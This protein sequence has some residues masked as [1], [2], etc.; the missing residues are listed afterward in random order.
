MTLR[1]CK[2]NVYRLLLM[3]CV[4]AAGN[5]VHAAA[6]CT[7]AATGPV[8]GVYNPLNASPTLANGTVSVTCTWT[9]GG[10]TTVNV[11]SSYTAGN[12]GS[13]ASRFMLSGVNRLNYNLYYDAAFTQIRGDGTGGSQ[14]G[15]ATLVVSS[16]TR[17]DSAS[18][19][20]YGRI[21]A[22]QNA[23]PGSYLDTIT[24]IVTY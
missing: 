3:L 6:T 10:S 24:M 7:A 18:S 13:Y 22:G 1:D 21:P 23:V 4:S 19:V 12:S 2:A 15:G 14:T 20:I 16:G 8:F 17:T 11:V 5:A 9:G